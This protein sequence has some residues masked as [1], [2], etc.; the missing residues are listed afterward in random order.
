MMIDGVGNELL[1]TEEVKKCDT[2]S[3]TELGD[4]VSE[5]QN[6]AA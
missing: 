2:F 4:A 6:L 5:G 3:V 1:R